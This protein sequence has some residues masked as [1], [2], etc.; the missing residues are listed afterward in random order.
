MILK[1]LLWLQQLR[2]YAAPPPGNDSGHFSMLQQ[3]CTVCCGAATIDPERMTSFLASDPYHFKTAMKLVN[4]SGELYT[5]S[6]MFNV[7]YTNVTDWDIRISLLTKL[8]EV[9]DRYPDLNVTV[10]DGGAMFVDQM[11][12]LKQTATL[13]LLSMV[14]V[15]AV[16]MPSIVS[17]AI[18]SLSIASVSVGVIG[19]MSQMH[20]DLDPILMASL[21]MT[22][23][24]SVDY[25]AHISYHSQ[26]LV[27]L[28]LHITLLLRS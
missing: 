17:V 27:L 1:V 6:F 9:I 26:V 23:G 12:S 15:C 5:E 25:I 7:V 11:L 16:F 19:I 22:I 4:D 13:T 24:M 20:F 3:A 2:H 28:I 10:F 8:R 21:L 14:V 18:A